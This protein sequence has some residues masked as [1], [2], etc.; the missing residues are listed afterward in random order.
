MKK[1]ISSL[2]VVAVLATFGATPAFALASSKFAAE[3]SDVTLVPSQTASDWTTSLKC[4]ASRAMRFMAT[5]GGARSPGWP[6]Y[7]TRHTLR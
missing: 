3:L 1:L 4:S 6:S 5:C 2:A 7:R